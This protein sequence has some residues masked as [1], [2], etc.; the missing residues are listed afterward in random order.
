MLAKSRAAEMTKSSGKTGRS[1][2]KTWSRRIESACCVAIRNVFD[3]SN[4]LSHRLERCS[5]S[6]YAFSH[7][8]I[9]IHSVYK[10]IRPDLI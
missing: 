6:L 4:E 1:R 2:S 10:M 9:P 8:R 7:E 5:P 3:E